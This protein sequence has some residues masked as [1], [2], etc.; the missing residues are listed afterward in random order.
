[1]LKNSIY[2]FQTLISK[3]NLE[4]NNS[5]KTPYPKKKHL[6]RLQMKGGGSLM[7]TKVLK[8]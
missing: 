1:M 6:R 4:V 2:D 5:F 3:Q 8:K 7:P